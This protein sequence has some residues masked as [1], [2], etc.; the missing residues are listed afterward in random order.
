M[1]GCDP[2]LMTLRSRL[3]HRRARINQQINKELRMRAGAENLFRATTNHKVRETVALELSFVNSNLQLLKEE[4]EELNSNM[5]VYQ[6]ESES[7]NVP[8][9][10]LGLK[11]T[12]E[13]DLS[14]ALKDFICEHYGEDGLQYENEIRELADLRQAMRT[15]SRSE[16]GVEL[17]MEYYNQLYFLDQRFF[18]VGKTL[19]VYFHWYDSLTGVPSCQ[20]ALAFEKGSVLFNMGALYTQIGARQDRCTSEGIDSAIEAFQ[21]AAGAFSYLKENFSNA[22]SLDMSAASLAMLVRLMLAQVQECVFERVLLLLRDDQFTTHLQ[23]AQ[24]AAQVSDMYWL[25]L[26]TMG[27]PLVKDYVPFSWATMAQVKT[28][29]FRALSHYYAAVALCEHAQSTQWDDGAGERALHHFHTSTPKGPPLGHV[30]QDPEERRK[31]GKAHLRRAIMRHEE[32]MRVHSLCKI[33]RKMDILQEVLSLMH[34]RSLHCYS[35]ID[36]EDDFFE[37][38]EAPDVQSKTEQKPEIKTPDFSRVQVTD[39]FRRLGPLPIFS[40]RNRRSAPR[41]VILQR[42]DGGLGLT[43]RGDSPVLVAGV[44]PGGCAAEA[45]LREGDYIVSVNGVDCKWAKHADVVHTLKT[46]SESGVELCV[47]TL[48]SPEVHGQVLNP[49]PTDG[50]TDRQTGILFLTQCVERR[51]AVHPP[52]G[53]KENALHQA[54]PTSTKGYGPTSLLTWNRKKG[55]SGGAGEA[56]KRFSGTLGLGFRTLQDKAVC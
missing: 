17:L 23:V 44:V 21:R 34:K 35:H 31:L 48:L 24:E 50:R 10:P 32:A 41:V 14:A 28:E 4:L 46:Y 15:P 22:P 40:A 45:G 43:L 20:R 3:Q 8:M 12:K 36:H 27:Q 51:A 39:I 1:T 11:E 6:T 53:N 18:P 33:L 55:G 26:Q 29:H 56:T 19:G 25:V 9:I 37:T 5:E 49:P 38:V 16:A 2:M 54:S 30:L 47:I 13:V 42:S 52:G 7:V